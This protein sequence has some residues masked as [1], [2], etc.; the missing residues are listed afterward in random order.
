MLFNNKWEDLGEVPISADD[1]EIRKEPM[2]YSCD[3]AHAMMYGGEITRQVIKQLVPM[4]AQCPKGYQAI[5]DTKTVMLKPGMYPC[6]GGWHADA[7]E[8]RNGQPDLSKKDTGQMH[9]IFQLSEDTGSQTEIIPMPIDVPTM[10]LRPK[11]VWK[12]VNAYINMV[13]PI[14]LLAKEGSIYA[15]G[16]DCL[17]RGTAAKRAGWRYFFRLSFMKS[18]PANEIRTQV[19]VYTDINGGW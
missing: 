8:R 12:S 5:I 18:T 2:V 14:P 1:H 3:V 10:A 13:D 19:N 9:Y 6:I 7:I 11:A 16:S 4:L 17:H 15:M